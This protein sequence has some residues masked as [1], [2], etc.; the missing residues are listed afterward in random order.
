MYEDPEK[1]EQS[2]RGWETKLKKYGIEKLREI[3]RKNGDRCLELYGHEFYQEIGHK[4]GETVRDERGY[5]FY[6]EIGRRGNETLKRIYDAGKAAL[7]AQNQ[8]RVEPLPTVKPAK[9]I[10]PGL[11]RRAKKAIRN[12][13]VCG[14]PGHNVRT[15]PEA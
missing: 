14:K 1:S 15:C 12:C 4:G 7:A 13:S 6:E 9:R 8:K 3:N 10:D 2:R 11:E 5:E